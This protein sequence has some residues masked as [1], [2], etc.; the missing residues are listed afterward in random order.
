[1]NKQRAYL[2]IRINTNEQAENNSSKDQYDKLTQ[3]CQSE[4]IEIIGIYNEHY[5]AKTFDRPEFNKFLAQLR[6]QCN[7]AELLLFQ[8]WDIFSR[9]VSEAYAMI[10]HLQSYG[11]EAKSV[12]GSLN[13]E[14]FTKIML[15][16]S[17]ANNRHSLRTI[18]GIRCAKKRRWIGE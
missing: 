7:S 12:E 4:N 15:T 14:I 2:Y 16:A 10:N 13:F 17:E 8:R 6:K 1:M 5:S 18:A 9:N 11:I 3:Y